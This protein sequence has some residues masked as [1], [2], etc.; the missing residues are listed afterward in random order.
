M[1]SSAIALFYIT[2][3]LMMYGYT[4]LICNTIRRTITPEEMK[5]ILAKK[6]GAFIFYTKKKKLLWYINCTF[7]KI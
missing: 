3:M 2:L 5:R 7:Q 6:H 4:G 1:N